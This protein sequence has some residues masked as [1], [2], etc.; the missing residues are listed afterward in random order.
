MGGYQSA[1]CPGWGM[2]LAP[3]AVA[4]D[5]EEGTRQEGGAVL[6]RSRRRHRAPT[7]GLTLRPG[8]K[9]WEG[10]LRQEEQHLLG[11]E[12]RRHL[13]ARVT[14]RPGGAEWGHR[15]R[16]R[17]LGTRLQ[18]LEC[19]R[20]AASSLPWEGLGPSAPPPPPPPL[21]RAIPGRLHPRLPFQVGLP[22]A[23]SRPAEGPQ[24]LRRHQSLPP[25]PDP[26]AGG[27]GEPG[28]RQVWADSPFIPRLGQ[29]QTTGR[30][31][32]P[33]GACPYRA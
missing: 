29:A 5:Q 9:S 6:G 13:G 20:Q 21:R 19:R 26:V 28:G 7:L 14:V 8:R 22:E 1:C 12:I 10:R 15:N 4:A 3:P 11:P 25:G 2:P 27:A 24:L 18:D 30:P 23:P 33:C 17:R 31:C 16:W 32:S